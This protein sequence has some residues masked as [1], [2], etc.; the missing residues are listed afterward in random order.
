PA[1]PTIWCACE[2]WARQLQRSNSGPTC[3]SPGG[4]LE[5]EATKTT[6]INCSTSLTTSNRTKNTLPH[7]FFSSLLG[8]IL[9]DFDW[10]WAGAEREFKRAIESNLNYGDAH[11]QYGWLLGDVGRNVEARR[12]MGL[13]QQLDPLSLFIAVDSNVPYYLAREY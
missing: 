9:R 3:V 4:E 6:K 12:E 1:P 13:A 8:V 5:V 7:Q 2:T 11:D 10:D